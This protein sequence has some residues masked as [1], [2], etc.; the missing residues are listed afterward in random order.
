ME[1][2]DPS[3]LPSY[4]YVPGRQ[5]T[6]DTS[7][8]IDRL[9]FVISGSILFGI[10]ILCVLVR[11]IIRARSRRLR[12]DDGL[13]LIASAFLAA[14]FGLCL[15]LILPTLYLI[16]AL[17]AGLVFP[18]REEFADMITFSEWAAIWAAMNY[19]A[20]YFV[21]FA[22]LSFFHVLVRDM[23]RKVTVFY[24]ASVGFTVACWIY[25]VLSLIIVC[26]HFGAEYTQCLNNPNQ[27]IRSLVNNILV[28][29][30]DILT[31]L[32]IVSFPLFILKQAR[33]PFSR[34]FSLATML[35]LSIAMIVCALIRLV[36]TITDTREN[37]N[38]AAPA[39]AIY[40]GMIEA[41]VAVIM[42]SVMVIRGVFVSESIQ[43]K[44]RGD[45]FLQRI[46]R[47]FSSLFAGSSRGN[48]T[49]GDIMAPRLPTQGLTRMTMTDL[50]RFVGGHGQTE[51]QDNVLVSVDTE[52][53]MN[54]LDYHEVQRRQVQGI[55]K[56]V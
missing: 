16:E 7:A 34:K 5:E 23:P 25:T 11:F 46:G 21:K 20:I 22:F 42:T 44:T 31:D 38:G 43:V 3:L 26:P 56:T 36:G 39:W 32:L 1:G 24:W 41:C 2:F 14:A 15:D 8:R 28:A 55:E 4:R 50:R 53:V 13:V 27:H 40:W 35:C 54:D 49:S 48:N 29:S 52:Y 6:I 30:V 10:A 51:S 17:N 47:I 19:G 37:G 45:S 9:A 18:F 33:M 12:W